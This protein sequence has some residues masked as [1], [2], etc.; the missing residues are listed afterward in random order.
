MNLTLLDRDQLEAILLNPSSEAAQP[1][2]CSDNA[3]VAYER[4]VQLD[5]DRTE[6]HA[7]LAL[8]LTE[9]GE[10]QR[11]VDAYQEALL[12]E[13]DNARLRYGLGIG[14]ANLG[15]NDAARKQHEALQALDAGLAEELLFVIES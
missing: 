4:V 13:P 5:P 9:L 6:A 3:V 8:A 1:L 11:A 12:L 15:H 2:V 14:Y 7:Q 10:H